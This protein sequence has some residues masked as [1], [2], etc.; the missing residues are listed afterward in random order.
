MGAHS[1]ARPIIE[2]AT[3]ATLGR[4][5]RAATRQYVQAIGWLESNYGQGWKG[6]M[7]GSNN[8]GAVQCAAGASPC[9]AYQDSFP[10]GT[11]YKVSFRSYATPLE[12][13]TDLARHVVGIRPRVRQALEERSPSVFRASYAMR[14]EHYYGGFCP[15]ASKQYGGAIAKASFGTPDHSDGTRACAEEAITAHAKRVW[16]DVQKI[17]AESGEA[18]ALELGSYD[19]A[20][21]W[22]HGGGGSRWAPVLAGLGVA[23]VAGG[24]AYALNRWG[25]RAWPN[26]Y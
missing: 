20:D 19:D 17:A 13:A 5:A 23:L 10:D 22:W 4:K 24:G 7:V 2:A 21:R 9:I 8:W 12:G 15:V 16:A 18:P 1:N 11:T 14:R 6:A 25:R 26:L 3:A